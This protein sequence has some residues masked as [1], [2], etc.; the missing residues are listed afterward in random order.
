MELWIR[1]QDKET[2]RLAQTLDIYDG[3][4]DD[5]KYFVIEE[6]GVDIGSYETKERA[7]EVLDEIQNILKPQMKVITHAIE[8]RDF[9]NYSSDVIIQPSLNELQIQQADPFKKLSNA[10]RVGDIYEES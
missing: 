2:L 8:Q 5:E 9:L 6:S 3:S 1:S 10:K 7:L 4:V